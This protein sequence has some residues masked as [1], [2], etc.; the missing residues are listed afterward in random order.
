MSEETKPFQVSLRTTILLTLVTGA[1]IGIALYVY[2]HNPIRNAL[3]AEERL[4]ATEC[5]LKVVEQFIKDHPG[6]WPQSWNE[7][8]K[9][10]FPGHGMYSWPKHSA[11]IQKRTTIDFSVRLEDLAQQTE[12]TFQAIQP[13]G[14]SYSLTSVEQLL[15]TVRAD[16]EKRNK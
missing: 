4:H 2:K 12:N 8:E 1:L 5:T 6:H 10:S 7:L 15:Q 14:P 16:L 11:E 3:E 9:T 13:R